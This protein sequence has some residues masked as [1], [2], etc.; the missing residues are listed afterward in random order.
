MEGKLRTLCKEKKGSEEK[1]VVDWQAFHYKVGGKMFAIIGG[2]KNQKPIISLKCDPILAES[3]RK[4]Y[5]VIIPGYYLNKIHWNSI[6]YQETVSMELIVELIDLS[7]QLVFSSLAK[8]KQ[9]E[10]LD[11]V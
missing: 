4:E 3:L 5:K 8:R 1:F 9:K 6:Y 10:I 7:Y 2:D 11:A